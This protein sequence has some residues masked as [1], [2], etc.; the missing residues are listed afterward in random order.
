MTE[1]IMPKMGDGMEEG[2]L[3]EWLKKDGDKVKSGEV[4][5]TIQ[6]DKATLELESPGTGTHTGF[7]IQGGETVPVGK[8]IAAI[9]KEGE[10]LPEGWSGGAPAPRGE[11]E[12][13][14]P[15]AP[16]T[17]PSKADAAEPAPPP[18]APAPQRE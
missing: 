15:Q 17:A 7:L 9:V 5:G 18:E 2:T 13:P 3:V 4:I 16:E 6:T 12:A 8:P 14:K 1:V 10:K 11:A